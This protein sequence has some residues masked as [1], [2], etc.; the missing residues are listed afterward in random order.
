MGIELTVNFD[1]GAPHLPE[2]ADTDGLVVD[3][4]AAAAIA[5]ERAAQNDAIVFEGNILRAEHEADGMIGRQIKGGRDCEFF[6]ARA[7][8]S[9]IAALSKCQTQ[10]IKQDRFTGSGL[11]G[12]HTKTFGKLKIEFID[13]NNIANG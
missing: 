7:D 2:E 8:Q 9:A 1:Q 12:K 10:G 5:P 13:Q 3:I 4:G 11:T 6:G